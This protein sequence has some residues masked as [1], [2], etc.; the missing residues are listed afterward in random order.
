MRFRS[1]HGTPPETSN[2]PGKADT[3]WRFHGDEDAAPTAWLIKNILPETGAGL[4]SGQ[5][6]TYKTTVALDLSVSVMT[7]TPFAQRF[8]V[9]RRGG[10]AY[11]ALE[12]IGGLPSRLTAIARRRGC[13]EALPFVYRPDC[14]ALAAPH[15]LAKLTTMVEAAAT[16]LRDRF[17]IETVLV[18]VDTVVTAAGYA[19][20]G[21]DNDAA[22]AQRIMSVLSRLSQQTG[23]LVVGV[24]HFGKVTETGTRGSSAKEGH[25]DA[26][27]AL[28]ADPRELNGTLTN[29][30]LA[31]RKL[32]DGTS[33]LEL[34]FTPKTVEVGTDADGD[35]ITRVVIDWAAAGE[36]SAEA[37]QDTRTKNQDVKWTKSLRLLRRTL[38]NVLADHGAD[39][40]PYHDGPMVRTVDI[41][42]VRAEFYRSYPAEGDEKA[43]RAARQKAFHRAVTKARDN[44]LIGIREIE[45]TTHVWLAKVQDSHAQSAYHSEP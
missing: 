8:A 3:G 37:T 12:G 41:N 36:Q 44:D 14:P 2:G 21:D 32:R 26:V 33:G 24:D 28:L 15:A 43:K 18:F 30:R 17:N 34:P 5:W 40:R 9:K 45:E 29:T 7:G 39:R 22:I 23:A 11:L 27:L 10:V 19:K 31:V 13:A 42:I 6:G 38:M 4:I 25:A 20:S 1:Y 35:P 16:G